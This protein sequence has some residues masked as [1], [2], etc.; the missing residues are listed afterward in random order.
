MILIW[1]LTN[2]L[3]IVVVEDEDDYNGRDREWLKRAAMCS[4]LVQLP[5]QDTHWSIPLSIHFMDVLIGLDTLNP[6]AAGG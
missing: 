4:Y 1:C 2:R 6:Y 3:Y 5:R